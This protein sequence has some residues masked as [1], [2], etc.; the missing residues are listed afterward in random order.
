MGAKA[1]PETEALEHS[2]DLKPKA[3]TV[4][5][6]TQLHEAGPLRLIPAPSSHPND[7]LNFSVAK[8]SLAI[9][10]VYFFGAIALAMQQIIAGMLPIFLLEYAGLDPKI[11]NDPAGLGGVFAS[12]AG[13]AGFPTGGNPL[14]AL[15]SLP[16]AEPLSRVNLLVSLPVVL[17]G[18]ANYLLVPA[19][20][21]F[22]RR[23][24]L[25]FCG[26]LATFST[27]WSGLST[28]LSSHIASRC[29][30]A[31]G[32]GAVES[33]IP[34]I[35]QDMTFIHQRSRALSLVWASQGLVT[36]SLGIGSSY[37]VARISWRW[38]YFTGG[39]ITAVSALCIILFL[40]E[41]RWTRDATGLKG[42]E[43]YTKNE[44]EEIRDLR[45]SPDH[46]QSSV[47]VNYGVFDNGG[48]QLK[49][50]LIC[51]VDIIKT[52]ILPVVAY[53]ILVNAAFIGIT[54]GSNATMATV[55]VAPP[56]R[57]SFDVVGY[58]VAAPFIASIF[59]MLIG[60]FGSDY[61]TNKLARHNGGK[62][63]A[64]MN[65]W[66][67]VFPLFR[68]VFGTILFG[69]GGEYVYEVHWTA[70]LSAT[71]IMIFAFLTTNIVASV[72]TVESYPRLAGPVLVN[73]ASFRNIIGFG[74]I[75]GMPG[76]VAT[77]G[78]MGTFGTLAGVVAFLALF[79]PLFFKYGKTL[80]EAR[81]FR[82]VAES[83]STSM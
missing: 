7:P 71:A 33:L 82:R 44:T 3:S 15:A 78:Y 79:L 29:F 74:F 21:A 12:A 67:L 75:Y 36:I 18:V 80:R 55:L 69:I 11:L 22:G 4:D 10:S 42:Q 1:I 5:G 8:K 72:A 52:L 32:A 50:G 23:I 26:L 70:I 20:V 2:S 57:W 17:A 40:P 28:S 39:I 58:V 13:G 27:I 54:I 76:C 47:W 62:R 56:Y 35:V 45:D 43:H 37:I 38:L 73:I 34:L 16:G 41:T 31:L 77:R 49:N 48:I 30:Q 51:F 9:F 25:I 59:V 68:G 19:S 6:T 65:L 66:N 61:L 83:V 63:E 14:E 60:G 81:M 64:E 53:L 46:M 24:V